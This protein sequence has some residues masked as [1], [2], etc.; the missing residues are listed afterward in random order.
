[1]KR[2]RVRLGFPNAQ[3]VFLSG[4]GMPTVRAGPRQAGTFRQFGYDVVCA[5]TRG[6][7][8]QRVGVRPAS[9]NP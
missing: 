4:R 6:R 2:R 3:A 1:M 5:E 7:T 9:A 8:P